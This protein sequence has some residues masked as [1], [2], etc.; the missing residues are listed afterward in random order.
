[1]VGD[2]KGKTKNLWLRWIYIISLVL[3]FKF[4]KT[5]ENYLGI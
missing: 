1:M 4:D 5:F 2:I 3:A